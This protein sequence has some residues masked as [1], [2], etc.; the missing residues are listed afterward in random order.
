METWSPESERRC[1]ALHKERLR[2]AVQ[3][4]EARLLD[5][6]GRPRFGL[7]FYAVNKK[8]EFGAA[9]FRPTRFAVADAQ[10]ARYVDTASLFDR[11]R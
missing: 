5:P 1:T 4:T 7:T 6:Q 8:G 9:A 2:R 11:E 3:M 10:G